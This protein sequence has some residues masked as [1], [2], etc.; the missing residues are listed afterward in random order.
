MFSA[1]FPKEIQR[2][3]ADF[4]SDYVFLTV[5]RVGSAAEDIE[6]KVEWVESY[7]KDPMLMHILNTVEEGL[8]LVFTETKRMADTLEYKL[9]CEDFPR[10]L[11]TATDR[12]ASEKTPFAPSSLEELP[13]SSRLTSPRAGS[14]SATCCS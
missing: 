11:S 7:D 13:S 5:G 3:A 8:V 9:S 10:R 4:L 14:I 6:Q 12:S 2:L 1:T